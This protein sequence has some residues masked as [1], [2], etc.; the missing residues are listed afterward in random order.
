MQGL[1]QT[2]VELVYQCVCVCVCVY[3]RDHSS[4]LLA[5]TYN[6]RGISTRQV[7][8]FAVLVPRIPPCSGLTKGALCLPHV[9]LLVQSENSRTVRNFQA[10]EYG[11]ALYLNLQ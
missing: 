3:V 10:G 9:T 6:V 1:R 11:D 5:F 4:P 2:S 8:H 7:K